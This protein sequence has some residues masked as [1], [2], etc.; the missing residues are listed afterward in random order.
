MAGTHIGDMTATVMHASR[1]K[2][3]QGKKPRVHI[4]SWNMRHIV[5]TVQNYVTRRN[6]ALLRLGITKYALMAVQW[7]RIGDMNEQ[8]TLIIYLT[9]VHPVMV[10]QCEEILMSTLHIRKSKLQKHRLSS[11][12]YGTHTDA[13]GHVVALQQLSPQFFDNPR[14]QKLEEGFGKGKRQT[15]LRV[16]L[17]ENNMSK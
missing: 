13:Y 3:I 7:A 17:P 4:L 1:P 2:S 14:L 10:Q 5:N 8:N 9:Q 12:A 15:P 6:G 11:T 16:K